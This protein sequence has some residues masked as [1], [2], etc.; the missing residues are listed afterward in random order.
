MSSKLIPMFKPYIPKNIDMNIPLQN[1]NISFGHYGKKFES[2]L[3]QFFNNEYTITIN[4]FNNAYFVLLQSLGIK[5]GDEVLVSPLACLESIQPL[6][7]YGLNIK[8]IDVDRNTGLIELDEI[9]K[10]C[11]DKTKLVIIN[12]YL[13]NVF[14]IKEIVNFLEEKSIIL[15][16]DCIEAFGAKINDNYLGDIQLRSNFIF[17]F[18]A[19]RNPNT[20][21]GACICTHDEIVFKTLQRVR[22]NGIDRNYFRKKDGEI[23]EEYDISVIGYSGMM[24]ELNSYLGCMQ[25][26]NIDKIFAYQNK[27]ALK[28]KL[29]LSKY[30]PEVQDNFYNDSCTTPNY[31]V[32]GF[33]TS[34]KK[35]TIDKLEKIGFSSSKVHINNNIYSLF[36]MI[37]LK[38]VRQF[39][40]DFLAVPSGWWIQDNELDIKYIDMILGDE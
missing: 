36:N 11:C 9:R 23:N 40:E 26:D 4:S 1:D 12:H 35:T 20:V 27:N 38:N 3:K 14:N 16:N 32:Y 5:H 15:I 13:G 39:M 22:D 7:A 37:E 30:F 17:N 28:W 10:A 6:K 18:S 31:W 25:M 33:H 29:I 34:S 2:R 24:N 21:T 19:V 8:F